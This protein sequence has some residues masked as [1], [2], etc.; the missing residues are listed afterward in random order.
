MERKT[1]GLLG[2]LAGVAA[3]GG[4]SAQAASH[5]AAM[6]PEPLAVTSYSDLLRPIPNAVEALK[7][8]NA[9]L[10]ERANNAPAG[11]EQVEWYEPTTITITT[12]TTTTTI[13]TIITTSITPRS[14]T[15]PPRRLSW[16]RRTLPLCRRPSSSR[17]NGKLAL[18]SRL[19]ILFGLRS[20][21]HRFEYAEQ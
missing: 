13:T 20:V 12:T 21:R 2:A 1:A 18:V 3:L 16:R 19:R 5:V 7:A 9:E 4:T 6:P 8:H 10:V 15:P 11:V 17:R 14:I